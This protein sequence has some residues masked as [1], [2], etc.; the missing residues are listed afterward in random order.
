[1]SLRGIC[2]ICGYEKGYEPG[3][4]L[5][6]RKIDGEDRIICETCDSNAIDT[7]WE[8]PEMREKIIECF[9]ENIQWQDAQRAKAER[10]QQ[11]HFNTYSTKQQMDNQPDNP[12]AYFRDED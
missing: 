10:E 5:S 7:L 6:M 9:R 3:V 2:F 4:D 12:Q 1:M 8:N 11:P